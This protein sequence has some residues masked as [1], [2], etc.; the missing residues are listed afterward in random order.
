M[1]EVLSWLAIG[2][3]LASAAIGLYAAMGIDVRDN[4]DAFISDLR[5]QSQWAAWAAA[6]AG[7]SVLAQVIEKMIKKLRAR[8]SEAIHRL[9]S[10][11]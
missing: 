7:V 11:G 9:W 10:W 5:R 8:R 4:M 1:K 3:A 6:S 2:A